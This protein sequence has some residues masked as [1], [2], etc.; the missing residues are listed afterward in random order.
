MP[1]PRAETGPYEQWVARV[2]L[3]R[4]ATLH[5]LHHCSVEAHSAV[6]EEVAPA[7]FAEPDVTDQS[8]VECFD[9]GVRGFER[10]VWSADCAGE[11]VGGASGER[12]QG[13]ICAYESVGGL[14]ECAV[15][16][17]DNDDLSSR[18]GS[19]AGQPGRMAAS[20]GHRHLDIVPA[21][22]RCLDHHAGACCHRR[23]RPVDE[24]Q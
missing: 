5:L 22:Q 23:R 9:D 4:R 7:D 1:K 6:K 8:L 12:C 10:V 2:P 18:C 17:E 16:A 14:V 11:D 13:A 3:E 21:G 19:A 20:T 24:E 15:A